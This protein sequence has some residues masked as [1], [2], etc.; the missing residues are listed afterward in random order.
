MRNR[1]Q[2]LGR[3]KGTSPTTHYQQALEMHE[4]VKRVVWKAHPFKIMLYCARKYLA[5]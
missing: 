2:A 3:C 5:I 1:K 4:A